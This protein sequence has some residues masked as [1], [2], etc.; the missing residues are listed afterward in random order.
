MSATAPVEYGPKRVRSALLAGL[1]A[2]FV[3]NV[4][5]RRTDQP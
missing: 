5:R 1:A 3:A 4:A 2:F